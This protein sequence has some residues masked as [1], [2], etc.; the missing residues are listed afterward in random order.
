MVD[1]NE[2]DTTQ[3]D[4]VNDRRTKMY[5]STQVLW[6]LFGLLEG[7]L[8]LRFI[9][10]LIGVNPENVFATFL[11]GLTD[12]FLTP[13]ADLTSAITANGMSLEFTTL[14]AMLVYA[15]VGWALE[16]IIYVIFYRPRTTSGTN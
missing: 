4:Q 12:I 15:L 10:K 16:R 7:L 9:F 2:I 5:V 14:I 8:G 6:L 11:Y 1:H 13:F 3:V